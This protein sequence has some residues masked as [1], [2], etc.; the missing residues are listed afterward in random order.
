MKPR[1]VGVRSYHCTFSLYRK[2]R[3]T[4]TQPNQAMVISKTFGSLLKWYWPTDRAN[5][6][7]QALEAVRLARLTQAG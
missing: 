3:T 2:A 5:G 4:Y 7:R 1:Y 6:T